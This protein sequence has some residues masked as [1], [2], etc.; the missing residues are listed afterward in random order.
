MS[1]SANL[2]GRG[3]GTCAGRFDFCPYPPALA[4]ALAT[5]DEG[6]Q[7]AIHF[8]IAVCAFAVSFSRRSVFSRRSQSGRH[9]HAGQST[10]LAVAHCNGCR[11]VHPLL[12]RTEKGSGLAHRCNYSG[13]ALHAFHW[14]AAGI[15]KVEL[16]TIG[17]RVCHQTLETPHCA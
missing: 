7:L 5:M 10:D 8:G 15:H 6:R 1:A 13:N 11:R 14:Q 17:L 9:R 2:A 3:M 16:I 12:S 4:Q